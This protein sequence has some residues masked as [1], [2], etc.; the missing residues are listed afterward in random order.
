MKKEY[1][2]VVGTV[3]FVLV[4]FILSMVIF[5]VRL[6]EMEA[7]EAEVV[8]EPIEI[9]EA[10][11]V[12]VIPMEIREYDRTYFDV[13]L[14]EDIQDC[15]FVLCEIYD[16]DPALVISII[17]VESRYNSHTIGDNGNSYGL[18]QVQPRWHEARMAS[19]GCDDLLDPYQN[20]MVGV[21]FLAELFE[22]GESVEWVLMTYNGGREHAYSH[23]SNGTVSDY[24]SSVLNIYNDLTLLQ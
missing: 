24:A 13:P 11:E 10:P 6:G 3:I 20:V 9:R 23:I 15:I 4:L 12:D 22:S 8:S 17:Q 14:D 21:N 18:M 7:A 1:L 2:K 19:L 16:V 5:T